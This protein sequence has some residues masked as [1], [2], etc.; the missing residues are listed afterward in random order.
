MRHYQ[1]RRT[2]HGLM[3][4]LGDGPITEHVIEVHVGRVSRCRIGPLYG[5]LLAEWLGFGL[6]ITW[7]AFWWSMLWYG[8]GEVLGFDYRHYAPR[9][10]RDVL[11]GRVVPPHVAWERGGE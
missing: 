11:A 5:H 4:G 9:Y 10:R 8:L 3:L 6:V 7:P 2:E 1:C